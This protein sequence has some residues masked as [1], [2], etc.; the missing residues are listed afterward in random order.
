MNWYG[1]VDFILCL[2]MILNWKKIREFFS[3]IPLILMERFFFFFFF[4]GKNI[5]GE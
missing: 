4:S 3:M 5:Y 2:P 1:V